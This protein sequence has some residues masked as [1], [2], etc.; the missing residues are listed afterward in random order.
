MN[1]VKI[2]CDSLSDLIETIG[3][4]FEIQAQKIINYIDN[5][6]KSIIINLE[7]YNR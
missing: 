6:N 7:Y 4:D 2:I 3:K 5:Y 1:N